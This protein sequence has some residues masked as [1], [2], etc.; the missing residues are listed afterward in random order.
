MN[1]KNLAIALN[2]LLLMLCAGFFMRHGTPKSVI[3]WISA[4]LWAL[5][6]LV[7]LFYIFKKSRSI[8]ITINILKT[9][10]YPDTIPPSTLIT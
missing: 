5:A 10:A 1:L 8:F 6:P 9:K 3:L 4:I 7:N 2:V